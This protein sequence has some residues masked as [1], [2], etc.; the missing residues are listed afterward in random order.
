MNIVLLNFGRFGI[1]GLEV[2][3]VSFLLNVLRV[4]INFD[5]SFA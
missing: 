2:T 5:S 3:F 1:F 4:E